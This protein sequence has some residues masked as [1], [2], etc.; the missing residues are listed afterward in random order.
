MKSFLKSRGMSCIASIRAVIVG[1]IALNFAIAG[2]GPSPLQRQSQAASRL[3]AI[4]KQEY[5]L[6]I[7]LKKFPNTLW[8]YV[9]VREDFLELKISKEG[10]QE[11]QPPTEAQALHYLKGQYTGGTFHFRYDIDLAK[12]SSPDR[13]YGMKYTER[14]AVLR[15]G[16]LTAVSRAYGDVE[17]RETTH[18]WHVRIDGD[19]EISDGKEERKHKTLVHS[20]VP[21][22]AVPDFFVVVLADIKTGLESRTLTY[23]GD[24]VRGK[25]DYSFMEEYTRRIVTEDTYGDLRIKDDEHGRHL[26]AYDLTWHEFL[27][28]QMVSRIRFKYTQSSFPPGEDPEAEILKAVASTLGAYNFKDY[29]HVRLDNLTTAQGHLY[30]P[31][32]VMGY[33][34]R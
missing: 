1:G 29:Q 15:Q 31:E 6:D 34:E 8:I 32:Q 12:K 13:G 7:V 23:I 2:C 33:Y 25:T 22:E 17:R 28:K 4:C 19:V 10:P 26:D 16:L 30:D 11:D 3:K 5:G 20:H 9:P 27:T 18:R 24:L 21:T 14:F